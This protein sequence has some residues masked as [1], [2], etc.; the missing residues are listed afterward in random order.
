MHA[1]ACNFTI[2]IRVLKHRWNC[3][4]KKCHWMNLNNKENTDH[5]N[6]NV[7]LFAFLILFFGVSPKLN[8]HVCPG[9]LIKNVWFRNDWTRKISISSFWRNFCLDSFLF[10]LLVCFYYKTRAFFQWALWLHKLV[11]VACICKITSC[12]SMFE[13]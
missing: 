4:S 3:S 11:K 12:K 6:T 5:P 8:V 7:N 10:F 13:Q 9:V 1:C 2:Q